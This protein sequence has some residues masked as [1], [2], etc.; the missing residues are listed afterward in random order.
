VKS[1]VPD[2]FRSLGTDESPG[3]ALAT[4]VGDVVRAGGG[5]ME[6][7]TP[8]SAAIAEI[9]GGLP[10]G[11]SIRAVFSGVANAVIDASMVD[12]AL[13]YEAMAAAG[14]GLGALGTGRGL[15]VGGG[16]VDVGSFRPAAGCRSLCRDRL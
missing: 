9:G 1:E 2:W 12:T 11:R 10:A 7:G 5:E 13:S 6:L 4:V 3:N 15:T 8:L 16:V 14:T